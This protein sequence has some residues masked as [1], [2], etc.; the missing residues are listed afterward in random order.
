VSQQQENVAL[1]RRW[2]EEVWNQGRFEAIDEMAD[3]AAT[4]QGQVLI[5]AP[6]SLDEFRKFARHLRSA[7]PDFHVTGSGHHRGTGS[8]VL[9]WQTSMTHTGQFL[10]YQATGREVVVSGITILRVVNGKIVAGWDKWDQLGLLEQIGVV[11]EQ[12]PRSAA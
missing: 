7:F 11:P 12:Y 5:D 4:G 10:R 2:F 9:R 3:P 6:I 8:V 1:A